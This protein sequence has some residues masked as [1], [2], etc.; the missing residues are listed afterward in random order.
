MRKKKI[1]FAAIQAGGGH[2][3][4]AEVII[5]ALHSLYPGKY[6]L[7]LLDFMKDLGCHSVDSRHKQSWRWM[8]SHPLLTKTLQLLSYAGGALTRGLVGLFIF[9]FYAYLRR[10]LEAEKPDLVVSTHFFNTLAISRVRRRHA[11]EVGLINCL[12]EIFDCNAYWFLRD[13]DHYLVSSEHVLKQ[14]IRRHFPARKLHLFSYPVPAPRSFTGPEVAEIRKSLGVDI[15]QQTLMISFGG[16]GIGPLEQILAR[17]VKLE[18]PLNII[19]ICGRNGELKKKLELRFSRGSRATRVIPLGYISYVQKV[20]YISDF[21]LI[22]PGP[23]TTWEIMTYRKPIL[24]T[25]SAQLSEEKV[26]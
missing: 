7:T 10:Y 2:V 17:M 19:V 15:A 22:K 25:R 23:A 21:C 8:L 14:M 24:F 12:T 1:V 26:R 20:I 9:P 5:E 3:K 6:E 11:L 13:V 16:E 18:L 4:P